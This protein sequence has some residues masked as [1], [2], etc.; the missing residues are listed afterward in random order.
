[1]LLSVIIPAFDEE[2][3]IAHVIERVLAMRPR[4]LE[5]GIRLE[6]ILVDDGSSDAT[7]QVVARYPE[8]RLICHGRN[9]GY[10]AALK[11]GFH[12][13]SG[14]YLAFLD[15]DGTYPPESL[16]DLCRV[17]ITQDADL[18]IG[19]R[20]SGMSSQ[21]PTTRR[22]GNT[23]YAL[24]LSFIGNTRV[25]DTASGMR[26]IRRAVLP[27]LYPLP[28]GL[29][30][31]PAMSTRA[32]H[33]NLKVVEMPIPYAERAGRSKLNVVRDGVRFTNTIVWTALTYNPVRVLGAVG[34]F[35]G[36]LALMIGV[37]LVVA[38]GWG[39]TT[40]G[41]LGVYLVFLALVLAVAGVSI[42]S[43]AVMFSYLIALFTKRPVRRGMFGRVIFDPPLDYQFG[44]M[45]LV[46]IA[47]G[48]VTSV[49][50]FVLAMNGWSIERLWLYLLGSALLILV[51]LQLAVAWIVMRVLEELSKREAR[52]RTDLGERRSEGAE[53]SRAEEF[54]Q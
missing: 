27:Q 1:M 19:S 42:F 20:M 13:A 8:V 36:T 33:E 30:F 5:Q 39:Y 38:R 37:A 9:Q 47:L 35:L 22:A 3:G 14:D 51:G 15:A 54:P 44:W 52:T 7:P 11:T 18:V 53:G 12:H 46:S 24:L 40:L 28:D 43:L 16:G 25:R 2:A 31:T 49:A 26:V 21:M 45:G 32:I 23:V 6:F 10:G 50:A 34:L 4:L 41:A 29:D 17:A 48:A